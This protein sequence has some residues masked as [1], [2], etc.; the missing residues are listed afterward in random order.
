MSGRCQRAWANSTS[1]QL[2]GHLLV[3]VRD[4]T[5]LKQHEGHIAREAAT[6]R[7]L[8]DSLPA[9]VSLFE[10]NGDIIQ[11]NDAVFDLNQLPR[12][13]FGGFRNIREIFRWQIENGQVPRTTDDVDRQVAERMARFSDRLRFYEIHQRYGRWIEVHW[14]PLPDGR[15]LIVHRDVTELK[16]REETIARQRDAAERARAEAEA[17]NQAKSTFLAT[18]S[19]EIR[20]PMNGVLGMMEVLDHQG[21]DPSSSVPLRQCALPPKR[22]CGSSMTCLIFK[23]RGRPARQEDRLPLSALVE[24][25]VRTLAPQTKQAVCAQGRDPVRLKMACSGTRRGCSRPA[26]SSSNGI[27]LTDAGEVRSAL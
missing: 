22:C 19:H 25:V 2:H 20:T 3:I 6:R 7:F 26:Q 24:G 21:L 23:D 8:L 16:E 15:R 14:I 18:M 12:D 5:A 27:K 4:I 10:A 17:A 13:V 11:M 9:G 1:T